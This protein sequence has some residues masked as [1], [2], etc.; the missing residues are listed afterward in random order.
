MHG[1]HQFHSLRLEQAHSIEFAFLQQH[2]R[3]PGEVRRGC[4]KTGMASDTF[5]FPSAWVM[6]NTQQGLA[7]RDGCG[8]NAIVLCGGRVVASVDHLQGAENFLFAKRIKPLAG[9]A[10]DDLVE[11]LKVDVTV[12]EL[13][14]RFGSQLLGDAFGDTLG[15]AVPAVEGDVW[16]Q[17]TGV[18]EK[19]AEGNRAAAVIGK[20]GQVFF[21]WI[22][23][24]EFAALVQQQHGGGGGYHFGERGGVVNRIALCRDVDRLHARLTVSA[25]EMD[26]VVFNPQHAARQPFLSPRLGDGTADSVQFLEVKC[27][28]ELGRWSRG[29]GPFDAGDPGEQAQCENKLNMARH[30]PSKYSWRLREARSLPWA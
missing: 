1:G 24:A 30:E 27:V 15:V 7:V 5:G 4:E 18:S 17:S 21:N 19:M 12:L 2:A 9:D 28:R 20:F 6:H 25:R 26:A 10:A 8:G 3:V 14:P 22:I 11:Q 13:F 23:N 29:I 16:A